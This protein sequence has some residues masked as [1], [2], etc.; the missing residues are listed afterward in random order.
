LTR[1]VRSP[2]FWAHEKDFLS[3]RVGRPCFTEDEIKLK[4]LKE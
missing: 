4:D 2:I 1:K 3:S